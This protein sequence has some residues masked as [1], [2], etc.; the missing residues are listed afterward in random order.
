MKAELKSFDNIKNLRKTNQAILN[1]FVNI[2]RLIPE[3][4]VLF[5]S[6][7]TQKT[8]TLEGQADTQSAMTKF[9]EALFRL[10]YF[11]RHKSLT[12]GNQENAINFKV[13]LTHE[14][15]TNPDY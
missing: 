9:S 11:N 7:L 6:S 8:L 3:N 4:V 13:E 15:E 12:I 1:T 14:I 2:S 10:Q 5:K